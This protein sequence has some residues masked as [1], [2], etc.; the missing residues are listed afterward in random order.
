L[1][2]LLLDAI[3]LCFVILCFGLAADFFYGPGYFFFFRPQHDAEMSHKSLEAKQFKAREGTKIREG[4]RG[5]DEGKAVQGSFP[6]E[7][8]Q[9]QK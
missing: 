5:R 9:Q 4:K 2:R 3:V 1:P 8:R 7:A 6:Q